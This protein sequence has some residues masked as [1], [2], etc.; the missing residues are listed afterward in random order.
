MR[1]ILLGILAYSY[2]FKSILLL[3]IPA[4]FSSDNDACLEYDLFY[5]FDKI[6]ENLHKTLIKNM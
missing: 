6:I 2:E 1:C 3:N 4:S 5:V